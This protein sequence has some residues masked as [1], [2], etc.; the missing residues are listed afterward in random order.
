M[1]HEC[2]HVALGHTGCVSGAEEARV[3]WRAAQYLLPDLRAVLRALVCCA[4][5]LE[6]AAEELWVD[7]AT[8]AARLDPRYLHPAEAALCQRVLSEAGVGVAP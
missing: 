7:R 1:I 5:D 3:R 4:G 2:F 8:V 6:A